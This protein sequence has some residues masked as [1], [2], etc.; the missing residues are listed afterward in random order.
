M[1]VPCV[2]SVQFYRRFGQTISLVWRERESLGDIIIETRDGKVKKKPRRMRTCFTPYQLQVLE[3]TFC[4][5]HYPDVMLREQLASYVNLPE[6]RIQVWFKNRRAKHRKNDKGGG[7]PRRDNT[8]AFSYVDHRK[9]THLAIPTCMGMS[10][11]H[12]TP[13]PPNSPLKPTTYDHNRNIS[14]SLPLYHTLLSGPCPS[15]QQP[16]NNGGFYPLSY[17]RDMLFFPH[18]APPYDL[19]SGNESNQRLYGGHVDHCGIPRAAGYN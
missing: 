6:A 11:N 2:Q 14:S 10:V 18:Q 5:T 16:Q 19:H 3:N 7:S 4:N 12:T 1:F 15:L 17:S 8:S 13:L 9:P